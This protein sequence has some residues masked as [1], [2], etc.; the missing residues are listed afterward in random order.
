MENNNKT[1]PKYGNI[2]CTFHI[3]SYSIYFRMV[4]HLYTN[5]NDC[6]GAR[7]QRHEVCRPGTEGIPGAP[8]VIATPEVVAQPAHHL[9]QAVSGS[10]RDASWDGL[11]W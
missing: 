10:A 6:T 1:T 7:V 9:R 11:K 4:A 8:E 5:P 3:L 2:F